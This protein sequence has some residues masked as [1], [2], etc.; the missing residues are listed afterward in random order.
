MLRQYY[1]DQ[2]IGFA[3]IG[4]SI[5]GIVHNINTPLA[6]VMGRSEMLQLRLSK[7]KSSDTCTMTPEDLDRCIKDVALILENS[8]KLSDIMKGAMKMA[9]LT[10]GQQAQPV[11]IDQILKDELD[12]LQ[13]DMFFK[14]SVTKHYHIADP[15][16]ALHGIPLH[17]AISFLELID[18]SLRAMQDTPDKELTVAAMADGQALRVVIQDT[19]CGIDAVQRDLILN[20]LHSAAPQALSGEKGLQ[21]VARLLAP[22]QP[23]FEIKSMPGSTNITITFPVM[24][25]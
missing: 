24:P 25:A 2:K 22:Y 7:L 11:R 14:H 8:I 5:K 23:K 4:A 9:L 12:F 16:P 10:E 6:A 19:G 17:F 1:D 21:R 20:Q 3:F 13:A 18:N 15:L